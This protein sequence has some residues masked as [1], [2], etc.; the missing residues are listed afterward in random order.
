MASDPTIR[1]LVEH[2]LDAISADRMV[3]V[4]LRDLVQV[5]QALGELI[6]FFHQ[7]LHYPK[8]ADVVQFMGSRGDGGGFDVLLDAYCDKLGPLMPKMSRQC[9]TMAFSSILYRLPTTSV[10][11]RGRSLE[12]RTQPIDCFSAQTLEIHR[13]PP[14]DPPRRARMTHTPTG[15]I[16]AMSLRAS[17]T[18]RYRG[19]L[20]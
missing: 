4:P 7:P 15:P 10:A 18:G 1:E 6:R 9:S 5:H 8:L 16:A 19:G 11:H 13:P 20:A 3:Q 12:K 14:L 2:G 17:P